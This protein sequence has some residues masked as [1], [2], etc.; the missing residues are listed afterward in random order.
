MRLFHRKR[1]SVAQTPP[2]E[3]TLAL[4]RWIDGNKRRLADALSRR[5]QR[6]TLRQKKWA[7]VLFCSFSA[8]LFIFELYHGLC[9]HQSTTYRHSEYIH[10]P[11]ELPPPVPP[12]IGHPRS[13]GDSTPRMSHSDSTH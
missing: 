12:I 6:M 3:L 1:K 5:E 10:L 9:L 11:A 2:N 7:L 4:N 8:A 13:P